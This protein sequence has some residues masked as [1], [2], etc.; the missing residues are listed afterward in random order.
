LS[1]TSFSNV[2][3][4]SNAIFANVQ[5]V[6][7]FQNFGFTGYNGIGGSGPSG[8]ES[9]E[10]NF[11][12]NMTWIHGNHQVRFGFQE[13]IP[14]MTQGLSGGHFGGATFTFATPETANPQNASETGNSLAGAL[15]GVPD[16]GRFQSEVNAVRVVAPSA[17]IQDAW[18][19]TPRLTLN[20]G[21]R[22]DGE[23][24][25]HLLQG[26]TAAMLDPNT[27]NWIVSGG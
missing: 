6:Y 17:Y 24:S 15:I 4:G 11:A 12:V 18:K 10:L 14:E 22:W 19:I 23:S 2:P 1:T 8:S 27:G 26:T 3:A 7:G 9:H 13:Q 21:L 16:N 5:N 20:A 25:P